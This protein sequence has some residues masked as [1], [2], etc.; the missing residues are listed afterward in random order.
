[1]FGSRRTHEKNRRASG[2]ND[3]D[4]GGGGS[5]DWRPAPPPPLSPSPLRMSEAAK[6]RKSGSVD[7]AETNFPLMGS[8]FISGAP[9]GG[10]AG[11]KTSKSTSSTLHF[12]FQG[13]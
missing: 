8:V 1:L 13:S 10:N 7:G 11:G 2:Y 4:G 9:R 12:F 5:G 3:Y 6:P